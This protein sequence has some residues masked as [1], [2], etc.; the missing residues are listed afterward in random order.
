MNPITALMLS[1]AI[2]DDRR[3]ELERR[4]SRLLKAEPMREPRERRSWSMRILRLA[5]GGSRG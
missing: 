5:T 2:E 1:H 3:R 4:P